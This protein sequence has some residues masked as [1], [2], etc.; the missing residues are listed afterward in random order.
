VGS[1]ESWPHSLKTAV[2]ILLKSRYPMFIWWG[3]ELTNIYNDAYVPMLGARHPQ[4]LG[5]SA[6]NV[7][8]DVWPVV[9]PQ[10]EVVMREGRST[11]NESIL[12]VMERY[13]YSEETY[14]TFS[15]SPAPNDEGGVGGVFCAVTEDTARVLGERRL[16]T[17]RDFGERSLA[18]AKTA[19]QA[20]HAAAVTLADNL[21]DFPFALIYL[22]DED[23]KHARLGEGV[24]L[25]AGTKA[26]PPVIEI[27]GADDIWNFGGVIE[28]GQSQIQNNLEE[29]FGRLPA[30]P[31]TN[32]WPKQALTL[33]L[34]KAGAQELP[35]GFLVAGISPRLAFSEDYR[36]FLEL[37]AR[38]IAN[39]ISNARAYQEERRRAE[40]LAEIDRAKTLFFS[41]VS[42]EFR[43]PLT[44]M[45]GPLEDA[46]AEPDLS[47][48]ARERLKVA[49]RNSLRLLKLVNM[50]LDFSRIE[51]GRIEA[52]FDPVDLAALTTDLASTFRSAI[53]RAG[54]T[55]I[56]DCPP[57]DQ[58][59]YVDWELWE[60]IVLNLISNAFK[61]TFG[62]EIEVSLKRAGDSIELKVRDTGVGIRAEELPHIFDRFHRVRG[63]T[64][65][66]YEGS[67][68]GLA[69]VQ[70]LAK[71][72]GGT[73]RVE[74]EVGRGSTFTVSIPLGKAHLPA[75]R[76][77]GPHARASAGLQL[78]RTLK[79]RCDGFLKFTMDAPKP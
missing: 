8:A 20:C 31:W 66:S 15:Y 50:L 42:H 26:S 79:R 61:F 10:A 5:R 69:L 64:G 21:Y 28:T 1:I 76:I 39:A 37:A 40:A 24:Q 60:K 9:G 48:D 17:L 23:G 71:L 53:E 4:A 12:L 45:L 59:V 75:D 13:G 25:A 73:A 58:P 62:G 68:I 72:H 41:N 33:A 30:G 18:E 63:V 27:G 57:L 74:S 6:P 19:E 55:L 70:E 2:S 44:L 43:T 34:A 78:R 52:S 14:F 11:W 38:Q 36:S 46:L 49:H 51:A 3:R 29:R 56:V 32:D 16:K 67:G 77:G 47:P 65:R 7:W 35:S 54:L 22:L